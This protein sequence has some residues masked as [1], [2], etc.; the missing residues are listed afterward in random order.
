MQKIRRDLYETENNVLDSIII[1]KQNLH[2]MIMK[3]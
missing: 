1:V 2:F 3:K